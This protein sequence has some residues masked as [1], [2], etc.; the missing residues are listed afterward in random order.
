MTVELNSRKV[1]FSYSG[2]DSLVVE[3]FEKSLS[4]IGIEPFLAERF[5]A[6]GQ[7]L[8]KKIAEHIRDSNAI[9]PFLTSNSLGN[10]WVNQEIGYAYRWM[11]SEG[12]TAPYFFPVVE[13][14][15]G[16]L[17]KGFLGIPV[18]EYIP[19]SIH[20]PRQAIYHLLLGLRRYINREGLF[21]FTDG[22]DALTIVCPSCRKS[23]TKP[24]PS[25]K[26]IDKA[27]SKDEPLETLCKICERRVT[28]NAHTLIAEGSSGGHRWES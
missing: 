23:F 18:K 13:D 1:F 21:L 3:R 26:D 17:I 22:L 2:L 10:Q 16:Q 5:V 9:V 4:A 20:D 11:E 8:S 7:D 25:Q 15:Q 24:L 12:R 19:L 14:G 28:I 27:I 6:T